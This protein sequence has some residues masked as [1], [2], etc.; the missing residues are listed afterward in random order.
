LLRSLKWQVGHIEEFLLEKA[1]EEVNR[2]HA[3]GQRIL[4][5]WDGSVLEKAESEQGEGLCPVLSSKAKR[6]GRTKRGVIFNWPAPRPVR[7]MG[8]Q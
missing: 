3:Q 6:R 2:L 8:M 4:C 7:V 1:H 5:I